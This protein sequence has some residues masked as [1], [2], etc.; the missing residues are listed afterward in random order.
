VSS[1][2]SM[3][4]VPSRIGT[5]PELMKSIHP[6]CFFVENVAN[7]LR[8]VG[9]KIKCRGVT[10]AIT[11]AITTIMLS[12]LVVVIHVVCED[13]LDRAPVV[14]N[15]EAFPRPEKIVVRIGSVVYAP[16]SPLLVEERCGFLDCLCTMLDSFR[17]DDGT[18]AEGKP[19]V[20]DR[21]VVL[22]QKGHK[23]EDEDQDGPEEWFVLF[24]IQ[25]HVVL[26][27]GRYN[28]ASDG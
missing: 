10:T 28:A 26:G 11:T 7:L 12:G 16:A 6:S 20:R 4:R 27:D 24:G 15:I 25:N 3:E 1:N 17:G 5:L 14:G 21:D 9:G 19:V 13:Q 22:P 8:V 18:I 23:R 2:E